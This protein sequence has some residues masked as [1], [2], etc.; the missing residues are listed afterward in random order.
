MGDKILTGQRTY[1]RRGREKAKDEL[2]RPDLFSQ[3]DIIEREYPVT[4][5]PGEKLNDCDVFVVYRGDQPDRVNFARGTH[6]V[7]Y[8]TGEAAARLREA[9]TESGQEAIRVRVVKVSP[10]GFG[11][12][13][14]VKEDDGDLGRKASA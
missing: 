12:A 3:P 10:F 6:L 1:R 13:R 7:G 4:P 5:M 11:T 14:I 2:G 9:M 8:S